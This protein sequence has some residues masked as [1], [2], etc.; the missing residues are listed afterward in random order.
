MAEISS[1]LSK[2][3][4]N[5][6][7]PTLNQSL[8][9]FASVSSKLRPDTVDAGSTV[10][11]YVN[12]PVNTWEASSQ[13]PADYQEDQ[14]KAVPVKLNNIAAEIN[15]GSV[16]LTNDVIDKESQI[17]SRLRTGMQ[18]HLKTRFYNALLAASNFAITPDGTNNSY[19]GSLQAGIAAAYTYGLADQTSI[20]CPN[21]AMAKLQQ[22]G[23]Q[24]F[25]SPEI[26]GRVFENR[27]G[28]IGETDFLTT[29]LNVVATNVATALAAATVT[30][31]PNDGDSVL[32]VTAASVSTIIP[33]GTMFTIAGVYALDIEGNQILNAAGTPQLASFCTPV[34]VD[35][36]YGKLPLGK[37]IFFSSSPLTSSVWQGS[38]FSN[39]GINI[40]GGI[41]TVATASGFDWEDAVPTQINAGKTAILVYGDRAACAITA[42][43]ARTAA[44]D[45]NV[46]NAFGV[47]IRT[48]VQWNPNLGKTNFRMETIAG[49]SGVYSQ[50]AVA[51]LV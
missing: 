50:A 5:A 31:A 13:R 49:F 2:Q 37:S 19:W 51:V 22:A 33:A 10:M 26:Q 27:L 42:T 17:V 34:S 44:V 8:A 43:P 38:T 45:E 46:N 21:I 4:N 6:V 32:N 35:L 25:F 16:E 40:G 11:Q 39:G 14:E 9:E 7:A 48:I 23:A 3:I 24:V 30:T 28:K 20:L 12:K 36:Q 41:A 47:G 18:R 1:L 29:N 15:L